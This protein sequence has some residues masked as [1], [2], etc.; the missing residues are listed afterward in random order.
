MIHIAL[1]T[2]HHR[3]TS[4]NP[5]LM[6]DA[7]IILVGET[8]TNGTDLRHNMTIANILCFLSSPYYIGTLTTKSHSSSLRVLNALMRWRY[9]YAC[10]VTSLVERISRFL[11]SLK[12]L[13][14]IRPLLL[15]LLYAICPCCWS[16]Y[17]HMLCVVQVHQL[18][19]AS[20]LF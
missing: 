3:I 5:T 9:W 1:L 19:I 10:D 7:V 15:H 16:R 6:L 12:L 11:S 2:L 14:A 20:L 13:C 4:P 8:A 18:P 17:I